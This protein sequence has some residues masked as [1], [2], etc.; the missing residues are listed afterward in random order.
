MSPAAKKTAS[1]K[2]PAI[3]GQVVDQVIIDEP[4]AWGEAPLN[5]RVIRFKMPNPTQLM[6]MRRLSRQL[7]AATDDRARFF[8]VAQFLDA[9]SA[10]MINDDDRMFADTEVLEGRADLPEL[11]PLIVAAIGGAEVFE[12]W[13][14]Q[15]PGKK[16]PARRVR[17]A[18][19]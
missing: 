13:Q 3:E 7:N 8:L 9:V 17:R 10:L 19:N 18:R 1:A 15:T 16:P 14:N 11:T 12:Q 2:T 4:V 5:G 6:V